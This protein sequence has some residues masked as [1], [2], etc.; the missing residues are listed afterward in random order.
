[1]QTGLDVSNEIAP[2][3]DQS[4]TNELE[5]EEPDLSSKFDQ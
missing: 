1:M 2:C 4:K 3:A 5:L